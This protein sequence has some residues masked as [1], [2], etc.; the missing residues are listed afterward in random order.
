MNNFISQ[1][2]IQTK[3]LIYFLPLLVLSVTMTGIFSYMTAPAS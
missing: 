3:L 1:T 2:P